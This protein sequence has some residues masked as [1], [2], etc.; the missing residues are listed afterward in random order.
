MTGEGYGKGKSE[1]SGTECKALSSTRPGG[2]WTM[3]NGK[4]R[5]GRLNSASEVSKL[6]CSS[7]NKYVCLMTVTVST[8][9]L[10]NGRLCEYVSAKASVCKIAQAGEGDRAL[11]RASGHRRWFC[12]ATENRIICMHSFF[13]SHQIGLYPNQ[14]NR[15]C[16]DKH[17]YASKLGR[18]LL[19]FYLSTRVAL[20]RW[21]AGWPWR[22]RKPSGRV[23]CQMGL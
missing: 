11:S 9:I 12:I 2:E 1:I 10:G 18:T 8:W 15:S 22:K 20:K 21:Q 13:R 7:A 5:T 17:M 14:A 19:V 3:E 4:E 23:C 16:D 6:F